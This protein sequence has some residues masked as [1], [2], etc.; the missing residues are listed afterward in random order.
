M[1]IKEAQEK[2]S[3]LSDQWVLANAE[4][5]KVAKEIADTLKGKEGVMGETA[6]SGM[7]Q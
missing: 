2:W 6:M 1:N 3:A 7:D 5:Q 4:T